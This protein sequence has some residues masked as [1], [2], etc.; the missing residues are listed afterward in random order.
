[1]LLLGELSDTQLQL[2]VPTGVGMMSNKT[3]F[4]RTSLVVEWIR[5]CAPNAGGL[6]SIPGQGTDIPHT[7]TTEPKSRNEDP[8][9]TNKYIKINK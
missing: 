3:K 5:L 2:L 4:L 7:K 9:Q 1:M 6:R 8:L